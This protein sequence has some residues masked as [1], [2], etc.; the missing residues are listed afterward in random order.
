MWKT[1]KRQRYKIHY[2]RPIVFESCWA[3]FHDYCSGLLMTILNICSKHKALGLILHHA[4]QMQVRLASSGMCGARKTIYISINKWHLHWSPAC[5]RC[6]RGVVERFRWS[7]TGS[8]HSGGRL[9]ASSMKPWTTLS[10]SPPGLSSETHYMA[11]LHRFWSI[12]IIHV[13]TIRI[14]TN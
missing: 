12:S 10:E 11:S 1:D 14:I 6:T 2:Y 7:T 8:L 9:Q 4:T 13:S 5:W 3:E